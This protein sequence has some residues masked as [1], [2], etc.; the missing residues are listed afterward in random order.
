MSQNSPR[1]NLP[2]LQ[3]SQAQ[4][5]VTHNEALRQ[6]DIVTQLTVVSTNAT[7]PPAASDQ[8]EIHALGN[9]PTGEWS[10]QAGSLAVWLD[11]AWHFVSPLRDGAHGT[12]APGKCRSGTAT[13][14]LTLR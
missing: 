5:H 6:L 2:F 1:L 12:K 3:P 13:P 9:A 11:N 4:K 10:G 14:G 8:G 7:I